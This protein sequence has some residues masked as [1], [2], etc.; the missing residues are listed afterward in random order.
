MANMGAMRNQMQQ[1]RTLLTPKAAAAAVR[2]SA[3]AASAYR[4]GHGH[5][6]AVDGCDSMRSS[7][8]GWQ[9]GLAD[10][11]FNVAQLDGVMALDEIEQLVA[12][13]SGF[14]AGAVGSV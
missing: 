6:A 14:L 3:A 7:S 11:G 5:A 1:L 13:V 10:F 9:G 8:A 2:A 4:G 12:Q